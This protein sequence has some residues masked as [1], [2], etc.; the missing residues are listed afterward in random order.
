MRLI[1][2]G[3]AVAANAEL[4]WVRH[5]L[6]AKP[7]PVRLR[8][9]RMREILAACT[10]GPDMQTSGT[11]GNGDMARAMT[12]GGEG[13]TRARDASGRQPEVSFERDGSILSVDKR[14]QWA[15]VTIT[16]QDG[17]R[18]LDILLDADDAGRL[19]DWLIEHQEGKPTMDVR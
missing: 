14:G 9:Q 13:R 17:A 1:A 4:G 2:S 15:C 11:R 10:T 19:S 3:S 16:R 18:A 12:P 7:E 6:A 5:S 8:T